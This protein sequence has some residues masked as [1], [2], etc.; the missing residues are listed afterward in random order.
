MTQQRRQKR[1]GNSSVRKQGKGNLENKPKTVKWLKYTVGKEAKEQR[2]DDRA[3]ATKVI[4]TR[5]NIAEKVPL[6]L[7]II[8]QG[9]SR[10]KSRG[11]DG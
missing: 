11:E 4:Q 7:Q 9:L 3:M 5:A 1:R 6:Y 10:K 8:E 2:W